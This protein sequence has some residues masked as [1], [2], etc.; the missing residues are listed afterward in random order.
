MDGHI[1]FILLTSAQHCCDGGILPAGNIRTNTPCRY[2]QTYIVGG[3]C[4]LDIDN[5]VMNHHIVKDRYV[6]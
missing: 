2:T 5:V 6:E 3:Q 1:L 4:I